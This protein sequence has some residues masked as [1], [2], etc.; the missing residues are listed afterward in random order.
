MSKGSDHLDKSIKLKTLDSSDV[1]GQRRR[2]QPSATPIRI[3]PRPPPGAVAM[4]GRSSQRQTDKSE[5]N[6]LRSIF[7]YAEEYL[8][9]HKPGQRPNLSK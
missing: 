9:E 5:T 6:E 8:E 4:H 3:T 7:T 1:F 2:L